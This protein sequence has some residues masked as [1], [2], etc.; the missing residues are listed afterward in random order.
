MLF[1]SW[2][3]VDS[4]DELHAR[5]SPSYLFQ[6]KC[7]ST[8]EDDVGDVGALDDGKLEAWEFF[9]PKSELHFG[10]GHVSEPKAAQATEFAEESDGIIRQG[11][12][13]NG[14]LGKLMELYDP[15]R[16]PTTCEAADVQAVKKLGR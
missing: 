7:C 4:G 16:Q 5:E 1:R 13:T 6:P 12:V 15:W 2:E 14:Y 8:L 10:I 9:F 11:G 3:M